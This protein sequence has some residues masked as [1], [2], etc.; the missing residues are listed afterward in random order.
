[1]EASMWREIDPETGYYNN[2]DPTSY[3][4]PNDVWPDYDPDYEEFLDRVDETPVFEPY[5][6]VHDTNVF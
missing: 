1:M 2:A 3:I 6:E 4:D 5:D